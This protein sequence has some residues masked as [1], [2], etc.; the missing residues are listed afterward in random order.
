VTTYACS[1]GSCSGSTSTETVSCSMAT[2]TCPAPVY[3]AWGACEVYTNCGPGT[4]YRSVTS[5]SCSGGS[6]QASNS[7]ESQSCAGRSCPRGT[8]CSCGG[9]ACLSPGQQCP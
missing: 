4:Q 3:G 7:T 5:Y 8:T 1:G 9:D 2:V 6:C